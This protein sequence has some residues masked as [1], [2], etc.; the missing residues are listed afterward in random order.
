MP[1]N[2][3]LPRMGR[4]RSA[5]WPIYR[6]ELKKFLPMMLIIFLVGF[7]YSVLRNLK[8]S[9]IIPIKDAG[10]EI[11]API[12]IFGM[13]PGAFLITWIFS[14]FCNRFSHKKAFHLMISLF[15]AY[16]I[17]FITIL[18]PAREAL[19][20][21]SLNTYL[22]SISPKGIKGTIA[23]LHYWPLTGFYIM[24][25]LW[26]SMVMSVLCWGFANEITRVNEA[27]RSYGFYGIIA[28]L[29]G[30]SAG[31]LSNA[32][33]SMP[34]TPAFPFG[35]TSMDQ[36]V[37]FIMTLVIL[38]G[39]LIMAVHLWMHKNVLTDSRF[40]ISQEESVDCKKKKKPKLSMRETFRYL[41]NS[42]YAMRLA[43]IVI[44]YNVVINLL[45]ILW[46]DKVRALYP[47]PST[48]FA[49]MNDVTIWTAVLATL[50]GLF[51]TS[52]AIRKLGWTFTAMIAP[53][54]LLLTSVG[55]FGLLLFPESWNIVAN[56]IQSALPEGQNA[57]LSLTQGALLLSPLSVAVFIGTSQNCL[58]RATKYTV[59]DATKEL[60][61]IPLDR[62]VK[63]KTKAAIDGFGSR[64]GKSGGA[65]IHWSCTAVLGSLSA[66]TPYVGVFLIG[67]IIYWIN[68][69]THLGT[70]FNEL[71]SKKKI[72]TDNLNAQQSLQER[73]EE[74]NPISKAE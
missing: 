5:L 6:H 20:L 71:T 50:I 15:L 40:A 52:N 68:S 24:S 37:Y 10:A 4:L 65:A 17:I 70:K 57:L 16:F 2:S 58:S 67:I 38:N 36:T 9:L 45:E 19:Q 42:S 61:F 14:K 69:V 60:A 47:E 31:Y 30:I 8:D 18:Y 59:F 1:S 51:V 49:Y 54:L 12:K 41:L 56:W 62:D 64:I 7:N 29:A 39:F 44:A 11:I 25:E 72:K 46:K 28:N 21:D 27:K 55:F 32:F 22:L 3:E 66:V 26:S 63:I 23:M 53:V 34:F 74:T 13:L 33:N 48:Y 73:K 43:I 35:Q